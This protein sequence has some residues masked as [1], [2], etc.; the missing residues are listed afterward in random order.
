MKKAHVL[1]VLLT[2]S[3]ILLLGSC[4]GVEMDLKINP[5]GSGT[6]DMTFHISQIF[7]QMD[8]ESQDV[9]VPVTKEEMESS[10]EGVEGITVVDVTEKDTEEKKIITASLK[11]DSVEALAG[12]DQ[13][14]FQ[15][16]VIEKSGGR[17][18]FRAL[19]KEAVEPGMEA[20]EVDP[21]QEAMMK[22]YFAGF[23]FVYRVRA[24]G[25]IRSHSLGELS[26]DG[27]TLTFEMPMYD[28]N[29][30]KNTEPLVMELSW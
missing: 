9:P 10:Y 21:E 12:G 17:T 4:L 3:A 27:R 1:R 11:F 19:L 7:F 23:S 26:A 8:P 28:F 2:G 14:M 18:V 25:K 15:G 22:P 24:P 29:N 13:E 20:A 6:A 5:N 30:L 16:A